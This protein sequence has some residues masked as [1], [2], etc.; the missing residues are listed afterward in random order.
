MYFLKIDKCDRLWVLDTGILETNSQ[1]VC[2]AQIFVF[3]LKTDTL[4]DKI[5]IPYELAQN[6]SGTGLLTAILVETEG[7]NCQSTKVCIN[8]LNL[9][10]N[11]IIILHF[12]IQ[13]ICVRRF[14]SRYFDME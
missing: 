1:R 6:G 7:T 3:N 8:I 10:F 2:S 9:T 4:I 14:G 13:G 12:E 11:K 5:S